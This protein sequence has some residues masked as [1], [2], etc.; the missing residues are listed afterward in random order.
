MPS[1]DWVG[2]QP[3]SMNEAHMTKEELLEKLRTVQVRNGRSVYG[4]DLR[5][6]VLEFSTPRI[7]AA[8]TA[9]IARRDLLGPHP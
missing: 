9:A 2:I 5:N 7:A 4:T 8:H 6:A 1:I 3:P